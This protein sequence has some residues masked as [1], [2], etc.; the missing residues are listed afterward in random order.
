MRLCAMTADSTFGLDELIL[1]RTPCGD[2]TTAWANLGLWDDAESYPDA[3]RAL[4]LRLGDALELS[5][6]QRVLDVGFGLGEQI[7][8]W[9]THYGVDSVLGFNP[10]TI[11]VSYAQEMLERASLDERA[12]LEPKNARALSELPP[13]SFER[14]LALDSAYHFD[15][16]ERF[17]HEATRLLKPGG[18]LGLIDIVPTKRALSGP[19][20]LITPLL[21][22]L[23]QVPRANLYSAD[24]YQA[25]LARA[26]HSDF[27]VEDLSESIFPGFAQHIHRHPSAS[28]KAWRKM[29]LTASILMGLYDTHSIRA[30][31]VTLTR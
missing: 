2:V 25:I 10:S 3:A 5:S 13:A 6:G 15:T 4:A 20:R 30:P 18:K 1:N 12:T 29:R 23:M 27:T 14:I 28:G 11:Q 9:L 31:L 8:L 17:I 22:K 19:R 7:K 21:A 16:R 26:P 24:K